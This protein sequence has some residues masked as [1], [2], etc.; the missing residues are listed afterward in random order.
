MAREFSTQSLTMPLTK[1]ILSLHVEVFEPDA[2]VYPF[3]G[4]NIPWNT[5]WSSITADIFTVPIKH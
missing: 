1:N 5:N 4:T 2:R 3:A